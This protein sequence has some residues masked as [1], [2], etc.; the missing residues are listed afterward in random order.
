MEKEYINQK[1]VTSKLT[2]KK[3]GTWE[4]RKLQEAKDTN[5]QTL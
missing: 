5:G 4:R 1:I 3:K 2:G